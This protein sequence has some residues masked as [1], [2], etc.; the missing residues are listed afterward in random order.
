M[1]TKPCGGSNSVISV[2]HLVG[3]AEQRPQP[4]LDL[5]TSA[6]VEVVGQELEAHCRQA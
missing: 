5:E 3:H 1:S 4:V 6:H 2:R